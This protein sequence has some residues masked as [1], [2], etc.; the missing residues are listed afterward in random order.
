MNACVKRRNAA[1]LFV[2]GMLVALSVI[3]YMTVEL[4]FSNERLLRFAMKLRTPKL[5]AMLISAIAIGV[6]SACHELFTPACQLSAVFVLQAYQPQAFSHKPPARRCGLLWLF[7]PLW[8]FSL[9]KK[10]SRFQGCIMIY[11]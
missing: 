5:F 2:L 9:E 8:A 7:P 3:A 6:F 4:N 1:A 10:L 11:N